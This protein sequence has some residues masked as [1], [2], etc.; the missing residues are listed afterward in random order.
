MINVV[1][2]I[3]IAA[4]AVGSA[5][6][7]KKHFGGSGGCCGGGGETIADEK[8][9]EGAKIGEKTLLIDGMKCVNCQNHIQN[10]LNKLDGV[11]AKVNLKKKIAV[12][13][14][15]REV[16]DEELKNAVANAGYTVVEV[17]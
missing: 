4:I 5:F 7:A 2:I 8:T 17:K 14:Y 12:V 16:S 15:C 10:S 13:E 3:A 9:L 6:S 11:A 1:I